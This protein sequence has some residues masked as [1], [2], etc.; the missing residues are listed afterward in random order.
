MSQIHVTDHD[1]TVCDMPVDNPS[2]NDH[3]LH[4]HTHDITPYS[5]TQVT[6][7]G[8]GRWITT[9]W[10]GS[11][12]RRCTHTSHQEYFHICNPCFHKPFHSEHKDQIKV[13]HFPTGPNSRIHCDAC[14]TTFDSHLAELMQCSKCQDYLLCLNCYH[15]ILHRGHAHEMHKV[16]Q[17]LLM[18]N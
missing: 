2:D 5:G 14:G 15:E 4:R 13:Y 9:S 1:S 18:S 11:F 8:C 7:D 17:G 12:T 3:T 6:C 16:Y 10:P